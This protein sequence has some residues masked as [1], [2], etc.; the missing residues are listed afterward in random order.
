MNISKLFGFSVLAVVSAIQPSADSFLVKEDGKLDKAASSES[1]LAY[2]DSLDDSQL[3]KDLVDEAI[4]AGVNKVLA[5]KPKK[6]RVSVADLATFL[7]NRFCAGDDENASLEEVPVVADYIV[8]FVKKHSKCD[9][10]GHK[11][12]GALHWHLQ[13]KGKGAGVCLLEDWQA[14]QAAKAGKLD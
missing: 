13:L 5:S 2:L 8:D 1:F 6:T 7:A 12:E 11:N 4:V 10:D 3:N 9:A 14:E